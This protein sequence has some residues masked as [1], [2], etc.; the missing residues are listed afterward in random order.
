MDRGRR[1]VGADRAAVAALAGEGAGPAA[2]TGPA[3]ILHV[4][5]ND[6]AWQFLPVGLGF[7]S[8]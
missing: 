3:G 6:M 1:L 2:G 8:K 5:C 7:G 4:L